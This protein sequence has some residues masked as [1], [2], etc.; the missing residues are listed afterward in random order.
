M[1]DSVYPHNPTTM[2]RKYPHI[3]T[4]WAR[5]LDEGDKATW[6]RLEPI[7]CRIEGVSGYVRALQ[8]AQSADALSAIIVH[9]EGLVVR[10][11]DRIAK[12]ILLDETPPA[13]AFTVTSAEPLSAGCDGIHH[14]EVTAR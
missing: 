5:G 3:S 9:R 4:I 7:R 14:W 1:S 8:G 2:D 12:G 13:G 6:M 11:E 10:P